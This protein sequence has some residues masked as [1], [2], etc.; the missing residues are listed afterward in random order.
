MFR[1]VGQTQTKLR[2][3][4]YSKNKPPHVHLF[5]NCIMCMKKRV[6]ELTKKTSNSQGLY[7]RRKLILM[8]LQAS[9]VNISHFISVFPP[10][11]VI[12]LVV[13]FIPHGKVSTDY[14][15]CRCSGYGYSLGAFSKG[16]SPLQNCLLFFL[17]HWVCCKQSFI[18]Q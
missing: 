7:L 16:L 11:D 5:G 12:N 14:I 9:P 2:S 18:Q 10:R 1:K 6:K 15:L 13:P 8:Y 4:I 3:G 17:S